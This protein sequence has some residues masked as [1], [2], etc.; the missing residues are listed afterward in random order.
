MQVLAVER[1]HE[2]SVERLE[3]DVRE[4]VSLVL[5]RPEALGDAR[6]LGGRRSVAERRE[7]VRALSHVPRDR[8]EVR[9]E[10]RLTREEIAHESVEKHGSPR[11]TMKVHDPCEDQV[12]T[13]SEEK[14][15]S[16][17][18]NEVCPRCTIPFRVSL[19]CCEGRIC[20]KN[21]R[22]RTFGASCARSSGL[23]R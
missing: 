19:R 15:G 14:R 16:L 8:L 7:H 18:C 5:D 13:R 9:E 20:H 23:D 17:R 10:P 4:L 21:L 3:E 6:V 2:R 1:R 12:K 22:Q 11:P